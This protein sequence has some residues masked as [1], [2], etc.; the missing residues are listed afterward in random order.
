MFMF[1]PFLIALGTALSAMAGKKKTSY[2]LWG[3][4]L[5]ITLI[6]FKYH[7]TSVLNLSF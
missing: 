7:A 6:N 5:V 3:V 1:L 2:V 4:L